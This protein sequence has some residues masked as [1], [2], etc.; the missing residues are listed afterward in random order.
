[1]QDTL[2]RGPW[3]NAHIPAAIE[4]VAG[5]IKKLQVILFIMF[6]GFLIAGIYYYW[7]TVYLSRSYPYNTFLC[8]P[9]DRFTDYSNM[10]LMCAD[11]NPYH[12]GSQSGYPPFGNFFFYLF[13]FLPVSFGFALFVTLPL[14]YLASTVFRLLQGLPTFFRF[15][16]SLAFLF[17]Y[18]VLFAFDRG[19][20][21][22]WIM[23]ALGLFLEFYESPSKR[24]RDLSVVGL[25]VAISLKIYPAPFLLLLLKERRYLDSF[26]VVVLIGFL[27]IFS[28]SAFNGGAAT[29]IVDFLRML[30]T[31]GNEV[32]G[33]LLYASSN[34]GM[35]YAAD[36]VFAKTALPAASDLLKG[37]YSIFSL[38]FL[39]FF[40]SLVAVSR[41][42]AWA[43]A[44]CIAAVVCLVPSL[45]ND[46]RLLLLL[47]PLLMLIN[48]R[49]P[50]NAT[51]LAILCVF[52]LLLV[53][54]N[55]LLLLP[56]VERGDIGI[57]SI[58]NPLLLIALLV[59]ALRTDDPI[60]ALNADR[61]TQARYY[62][63]VIA[64]F[65]TSAAALVYLLGL[66][67]DIGSQGQ[68]LLRA[69]DWPRF[70]LLSAAVIVHLMFIPRFLRLLEKITPKLLGV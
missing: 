4:S 17:A 19:N 65:V 28:A 51:H 42:R 21:D 61:K 16:A 46:Y 9:W 27:T 2:P 31:T 10:V 5:R 20:L 18:P 1:M 60:F 47:M 66:N 11:L 32:K 22:L 8:V 36:I 15:T 57:S 3:L 25:A 52:G 26:K 23:S 64:G 12:T 38:C 48:S 37:A 55:Y 41:L 62:V 53:P 68:T 40:L 63:E 33:R 67:T 49:T 58:L 59:L 7:Q 50:W 14:F 29:A 43:S 44:T 39:A 35:F 30:S 56:G 13:S 70:G 45:S 24:L 69:W 34:V 6:V 54:K